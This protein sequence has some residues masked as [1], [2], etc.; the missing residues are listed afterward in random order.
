[1]VLSEDGSHREMKDLKYGEEREIVREKA[2][3]ILITKIHNPFSLLFCL[4]KTF[5]LRDNNQIGRKKCRNRKKGEKLLQMTKENKMS[6]WHAV[7]SRTSFASSLLILIVSESIL[8]TFFTEQQTLVCQIHCK[9]LQDF[10]GCWATV[11]LGIR[12]LSLDGVF[13]IGLHLSSKLMTKLSSK[14]GGKSVQL[15]ISDE[16]FSLGK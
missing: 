3:M 13:S 7:Y 15:P 10:P 14:H 16:I 6:F 5:P 12:S 2:F 8:K 11:N 1:M 4:R 9:S